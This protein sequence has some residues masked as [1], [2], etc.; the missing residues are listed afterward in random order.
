MNDTEMEAA[1]KAQM[2]ETRIGMRL[3]SLKRDDHGRMLVIDNSTG[4]KVKMFSVDVR[5]GLRAGHLSL[6]GDAEKAKP[7]A[8]GKRK[9]KVKQKEPAEMTNDELQ[10]F[11]ESIGADVDFTVCET[12]E[13]KRK[14]VA[15]AIA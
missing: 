12:L 14:A 4:E 6:I 1:I 5:E 3:G 11:C 10:D 9:A 2:E 8:K 7:A 13:D 15:A